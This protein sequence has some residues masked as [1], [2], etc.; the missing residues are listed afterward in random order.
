MNE[1]KGLECNAGIRVALD[2][3]YNTKLNAGWGKTP[4]QPA[5]Q[6]S[7][8]LVEQESGQNWIIGIHVMNKLCSIC[9]RLRRGSEEVCKHKGTCSANIPMSASIGD[10]K[11]AVKRLMEQIQDK[12]VQSLSD[13]LRAMLIVM[14]L[15]VYQKDRVQV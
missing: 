12:M 7:S 14:V 11:A 5:T 1:A 13:M 10:E 9:S 15:R 2:S 4:F 3:K 6:S 8:T